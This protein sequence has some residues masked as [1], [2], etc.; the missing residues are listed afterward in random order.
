MSD[1]QNNDWLFEP[2][3]QEDLDAK[4]IAFLKTQLGY[5]SESELTRFKFALELGLIQ[6]VQGDSELLVISEVMNTTEMATDYLDR[7]KEV[8]TLKTY[9]AHFRI[10]LLQP[11]EV[12][13]RG[14]LLGKTEPLTGQAVFLERSDLSKLLGVLEMTDEKVISAKVFEPKFP[15]T[16]RQPTESEEQ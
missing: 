7:T 3:T 15:E 9:L 6:R 2:E 11:S 12:R 8:P 13:H 10:K 4:H 1:S 14:N 16:S 5:L